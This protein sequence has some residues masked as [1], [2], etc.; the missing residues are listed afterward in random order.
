M[1]S[2]KCNPIEDKISPPNFHAAS[3]MP[4][5]V[6]PERRIKGVGLNDL[7]TNRLIYIPIK[8]IGTL[9]KKKSIFPNNNLYKSSPIT[10]TIIVDIKGFFWKKYL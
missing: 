5:Y 1:K 9:A 7:S 8:Y 6:M 4:Q 10:D 3:D 2:M